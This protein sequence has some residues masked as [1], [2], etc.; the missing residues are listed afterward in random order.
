MFYRQVK[1]SQL[2]D[3]FYL[4]TTSELECYTLGFFV[5]FHSE[6]KSPEDSIYAL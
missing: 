5:V 3:S 2:P 4:N 6:E 1:K